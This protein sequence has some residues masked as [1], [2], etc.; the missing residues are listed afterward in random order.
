MSAVG[1]NGF[2]T[3]YILPELV[4]V[5]GEAPDTRGAEGIDASRTGPHAPPHVCLRE[6]MRVERAD[7]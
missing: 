3:F 6:R 1:R 2:E 7:S 4:D 5:L